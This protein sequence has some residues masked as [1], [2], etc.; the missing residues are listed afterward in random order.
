MPAP[1]PRPDY[2][3]AEAK[4]WAL[5][6]TDIA[7]VDRLG[8]P[9]TIVGC[10]WSGVVTAV[11]ENVTRFKL[12]DAVGGVC[13]GGAFITT[14]SRDINPTKFFYTSIGN[15]V[16]PEDGA[17]SNIVISKEH[18]IMHKPA[19][20][21]FAEAASLGVGMATIGQALYWFM[22][23]RL[24]TVDGVAPEQSSPA[25]F[26]YGGSSATGS[27][28]IQSLKQYAPLPLNTY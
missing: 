4:A 28:A 8:G 2:V 15:T 9:G 21:S 12:G 17:Y 13:H 19:S 24:P 11:G 27:L 1:R 22:K 3:I 20:L 14:F 16:E 18:A 10:D 5:N 6:P 23:L 26:V 7:H 25:V